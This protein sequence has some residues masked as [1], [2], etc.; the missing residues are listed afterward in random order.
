MKRFPLLRLALA[1]LAGVLAQPGA[2]VHLSPKGRGQVLLYPYYS[3]QGSYDTLISVGSY[4]TS[5]VKLRLREGRNS[6]IVLELNLYLPDGRIWTAVITRDAAGN[7]I[8][9]TLDNACTVPLL[10][11][12]PTFPGAR[13]LALSNANYAGFDS[14]GSGLDRAK[15][16]YIEVIDMGEPQENGPSFG[17]PQ[18]TLSTHLFAGRCAEIAA[19]WAPGGALA[20]SDG[21]ELGL[22]YGWM[23]GTASLINV[24]EGTSFSYQATMLANVFNA[25]RHTPPGSA[26]P[27]LEEA[28]PQSLIGIEPPLQSTWNRGI[29]AVSAVLMHQTLLNDYTVD[30][31]IS[32]TTDLVLTFPTKAFLVP[33]ETDV[34]IAVG[35]PFTARFDNRAPAGPGSTGSAL[36][37][38]ASTGACETMS[39]TRFS[40]NGDMNSIPA[41]FA[42]PPPALPRDPGQVC[43]STSVLSMGN[44][45]RSINATALNTTDTPTS[46]GWTKIEFAQSLT[47]KEGRSYRGLPLI[48]FAAQKYVNG[49][50][51]SVLSSGGVLSNYGGAFGHKYIDVVD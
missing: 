26:S 43:W 33:R 20:T 42:L 41:D 22:N 23:F 1:V 5:A 21:S 31:V 49:N 17:F 47:S 50:I 3:A 19:A 9:R 14:A 15:E 48:G 7:P 30:P 32:A 51:Q 27:N 24:P 28:I 36:S 10:S 38:G 16:G 12:S 45:L 34:N 40:H 18:S 13:E 8:L 44:V 4:H 39:L 46:D 11:F 37:D 29:D 25:P 35:A 2:A 6:R